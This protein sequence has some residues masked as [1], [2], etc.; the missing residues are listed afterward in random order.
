LIDL[1]L[2]PL[3]MSMKSKVSSL[4][5]EK[6][7]L[8][9]GL[10]KLSL[11]NKNK[12]KN[13]IS[14]S[15]KNNVKEMDDDQFMNY[16][17][18]DNDTSKDIY[19]PNLDVDDH[20]ESEQ[21]KIALKIFEKTMP[22]WNLSITALKIAF[23]G[24]TCELLSFRPES[25]KVRNSSIPKYPALKGFNKGN[26]YNVTIKRT[27][28]PPI[29]FPCVSHILSPWSIVFESNE[30]ET[31]DEPMNARKIPLINIDFSSI[32]GCIDFTILLPEDLKDSPPDTSQ[33]EPSKNDHDLIVIAVKIKSCFQDNITQK[34][35]HVLVGENLNSALRLHLW[36]SHMIH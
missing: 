12:N 1:Q 27:D 11:K 31:E 23:T 10:K 4:Q 7:L 33:N 15:V 16:L 34:A 25:K 26:E 17:S 6:E 2:Y 35:C 14:N 30:T 3:L 32:N 22:K 21:S 5:Y 24:M 19:L 8:L 20:K 28:I 9:N 29:S 18:S 36:P 13:K